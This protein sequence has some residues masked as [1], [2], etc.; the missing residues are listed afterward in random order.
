MTVRATQTIASSFGTYHA[1]DAID[2]TAAGPVLEAWLAAGLVVDAPDA[3]PDHVEIATAPAVETA[4][5]PRQR[6]RPRKPA[7]PA[8]PN[9]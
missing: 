3:E 1:G 4:T 9:S 7:I 5:A 6:G 2:V 8:S